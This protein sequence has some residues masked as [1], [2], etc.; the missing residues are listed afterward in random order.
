MIGYRSDGK[1]FENGTNTSNPGHKFDAPDD[2]IIFDT[3]A[4][5]KLM[6]FFIRRKNG[7]IC[8]VHKIL[9]EIGDG[10]V[11]LPFIQFDS[12]TTKFKFI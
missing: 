12:L 9:S 4:T 11:W 7:E 6:K 8:N 10:D 3:D 5:S 2:E 1:I